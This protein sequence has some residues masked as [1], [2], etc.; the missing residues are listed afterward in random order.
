MQD[1]TKLAH[2]SSQKTYRWPIEKLPVNKTEVGVSLSYIYNACQKSWSTCTIFTQMVA[3][4]PP[5]Q[6]MFIFYGLE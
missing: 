1:N 6:T 5:P 4:P 2:G 3:E